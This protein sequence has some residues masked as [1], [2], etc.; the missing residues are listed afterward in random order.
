MNVITFKENII[1]DSV[2]ERNDSMVGQNYM[3]TI[4]IFTQ[5]ELEV[6]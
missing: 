4:K 6:Q 1:M 2:I 5:K 3:K